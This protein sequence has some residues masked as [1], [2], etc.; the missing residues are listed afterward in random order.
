[1]FQWD[2]I[3]LS[4]ENVSPP[5][6]LCH[7]VLS[8]KQISDIVEHRYVRA[9]SEQRKAGETTYRY[10]FPNARIVCR[11]TQLRVLCS[12]MQTVPSRV[13]SLSLS[14]YYLISSPSYSVPCHYISWKS[15]LP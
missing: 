3:C 9:K 8:T 4:V 15:S 12:S 11:V 2:S 1:M 5:L 7:V 10:S 14:L 6:S 13:P